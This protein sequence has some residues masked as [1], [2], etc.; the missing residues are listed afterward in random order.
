MS[1][2]WI[3]L[4]VNAVDN[5]KIQQLPDHLFKFLINCWC[6]TGASDDDALPPPEE[7]AWRLRI[8]PSVCNAYIN[9]L[10]TLHLLDIDRYGNGD[11]TLPHNW[12]DRQFLSDDSKGRV[13]RYRDRYKAVTRTVTVTAQDSDTDQRQNAPNTVSESTPPG[14]Y[15]TEFRAG[16]LAKGFGNPEDDPGVDVMIERTAAVC[17]QAGASPQLAAWVVVDL[18]KTERCRG[19]PLEYLLGA[20]RSQLNTNGNDLRKAAKWIG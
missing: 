2:P 1:R 7:I 19:K 14:S 15:E 12:N 10:V 16:L 13:K 5:A 6:L 4:Y 18:L 11:R 8:E 17:C 20:L 3:R 9:H